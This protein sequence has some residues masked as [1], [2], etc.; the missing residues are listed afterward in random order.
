MTCNLVILGHCVPKKLT[1]SE[2]QCVARELK[3]RQVFHPRRWEWLLARQRESRPRFRL[4]H[5]SR[6]MHGISNVRSRSG[7]D[8][9]RDLARRAFFSIPVARRAT[10]HRVPCALSSCTSRAVT[11]K[12]PILDTLATSF[13]IRVARSF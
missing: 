5:E 4:S 8:P 6:H 1:V 3:K 7:G 9:G 12:I 11:E 2:T 13:R 10:T